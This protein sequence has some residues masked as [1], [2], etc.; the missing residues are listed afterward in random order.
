[1]KYVPARY[2]QLIQ[3][4]LDEYASVGAMELDEK[5]AKE[6]EAK[7][8][9]LTHNGITTGDYQWL[10]DPWPWEYCDRKER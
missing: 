7:C 8:G 10:D 5:E 1:M 2:S 9:P 6:Y 4:A 3:Q